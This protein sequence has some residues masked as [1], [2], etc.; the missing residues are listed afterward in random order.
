MSLRLSLL[1]G[2][3]VAALC[4]VACGDDPPAAPTTPTVTPPP[5]PPPPPPPPPAVAELESV[6]LSPDSVEGQGNPDG[7][8]R[9]T[10]AAPTGGAVVAL[11]SGNPDVVQV[12]ANVT[13]AAGSTTATFRIGTSTVNS[14]R[15][16]TIQAT[17]AGVTKSAPLTVLAPSL[18][19]N[20][21]VTSSSRG[22]DACDIVNSSGAIDCVFNASTS[23][24]FVARYLWT[25]K[26][27]STE[28]SFSAPDDQS[29]V[30]PTTTCGLL[31]NGS[32]S[33]GSVNMEVSLQLEDRSGNKSNTERRTVAVHHNGRCGY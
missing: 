32:A 13:V 33:G 4:V 18:V 12:P 17:Y 27:G 28:T 11:S 29:T 6:T 2:V 21:T 26:V 14:N 7:T 31:G 19:P 9:L 24:G 16:V 8:V 3:L 30:T 25:M 5:A 1:S 20:F 10:A 23:R 15:V 22:A